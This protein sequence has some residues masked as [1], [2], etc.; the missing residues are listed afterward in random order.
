MI[1]L[2]ESIDMDPMC[3]RQDMSLKTTLMSQLVK[4]KN[5]Q[6]RAWIGAITRQTNF[7]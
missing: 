3:R 1:R 4:A 7:V 6:G 2:S 5:Q